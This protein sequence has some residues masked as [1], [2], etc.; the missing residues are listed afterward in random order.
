M[1]NNKFY[2]LFFYFYQ[3]KNSPFYKLIYFDDFSVTPKYH[4]LANC[5]TKAIEDFVNMLDVDNKK[6]VVDYTIS[7]YNR[8][9]L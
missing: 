7:L 9:K 3:M 6:E 5:I 4:Q 1:K 8:S 2:C